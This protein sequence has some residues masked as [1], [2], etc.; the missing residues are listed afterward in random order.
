LSTK[1]IAVA[2]PSPVSELTDHLGYWMR[3]VSNQVSHRFTRRLSD[4]QVTVAE[5][6]IMRALFRRDA[7]SP[8][9]LADEMGLSRG[10]IT[11]L[12]DR[13]IAKGFAVRTPDPHD[14]RAQ[15]LALTQSGRRFVPKLA[16][17]ADQNDREIFNVLSK[18]DQRTLVRI[19]RELARKHEIINVPI[20]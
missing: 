1:E 18:S 8:S 13:L 6:V 10:A 19:L 12:A 16:A 20:K 2:A 4:V 3:L 11:K 15:G 5:W 14:A 7:I 9:Q 17:L